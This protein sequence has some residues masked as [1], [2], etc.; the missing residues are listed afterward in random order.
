M[1][2]LALLT[3]L[4]A[5]VVACSQAP[6]WQKPGAEQSDIDVAIA[7][8]R[9]KLNLGTSSLETTVRQSRSMGAVSGTLQEVIEKD[10][11]TSPVRERQLLDDC[12]N[13]KGFVLVD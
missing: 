10:R 3:A 9:Q 5:S 2:A 13:K 6:R 8:C 7:E 12:M 11:G 4:L 1:R